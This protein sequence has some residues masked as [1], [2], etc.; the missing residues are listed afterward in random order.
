MY[1][2]TNFKRYIIN[3]L[4]C[5]AKLPNMAKNILA[6]FVGLISGIILMVLIQ[7]LGKHFV[8]VE[9]AVDI[10]SEEAMRN[11]V[12]S[13]PKQAYYWLIA[14]HAWG[15]AMAAFMTTRIAAY[16]QTRMGYLAAFVML[17]FTLVMILSVPGY[18]SWVII[19]DIIVLI[20]LGLLAS[21]VGG[22][23]FDA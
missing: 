1:L 21:R 13:L 4:F 15:A 3:F 11:Y 7:S 22:R 20:V 9:E 23:L 14:S 5:F 8:P 12:A 2:L 19:S 18:P 10:Q 17:L 16:D 6:V